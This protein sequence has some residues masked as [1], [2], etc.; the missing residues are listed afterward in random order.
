VPVLSRPAPLEGAEAGA[1]EDDSGRIA[2]DDATAVLSVAK[3]S[4][5]ISLGGRNGA[6]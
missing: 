3:W 2:A 6:S 4:G 1:S 5:L